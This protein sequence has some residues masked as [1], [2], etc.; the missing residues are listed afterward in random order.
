[1]EAVFQEGWIAKPACR[2]ASGFDQG[3]VGIPIVGVGLPTSFISNVRPG[4]GGLR[5]RHDH[6]SA[7][8]WS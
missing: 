2:D 1:M 8:S 4:F 3:N 6:S 5:N 7:N